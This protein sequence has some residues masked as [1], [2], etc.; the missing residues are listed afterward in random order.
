M[1]LWRSFRTSKRQSWRDN[2]Y[3]NVSKQTAVY[4]AQ[5][6]YTQIFRGGGILDCYNLT[7]KQDIS[8]TITTRVDASNDYFVLEVYEKTNPDKHNG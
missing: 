4:D 3:G 6:S 7:I 2:R 1:R 8:C 5:K